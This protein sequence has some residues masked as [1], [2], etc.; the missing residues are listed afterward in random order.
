M[1]NENHPNQLGN[2]GRWLICSGIPVAILAILLVSLLP[3]GLNGIP[4]VFGETVAPYVVFFTPVVIGFSSTA[5]L[6]Y[7]PKRL[8]FRLGVLG[9]VTGLILIYWYFWFG[10]GA[11]HHR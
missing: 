6:E 5:L 10:P 2:T 4:K 3:H 8:A 9:W 7:V 11:F 1:M